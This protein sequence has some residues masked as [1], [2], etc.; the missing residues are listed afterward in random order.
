MIKAIATAL[1]ASVAALGWAA[2]AELGPTAAGSTNTAALTALADAVALW[3]FQ[4]LNDAA[5]ANSV[6]R[7]SGPAKVG[8]RLFGLD[9]ADSGARGGDGAVAELGA[10][11][12]LAGAGADDKLALRGPAMSLYTR[13]RQPGGVWRSCGIVSKYGGHDRLVYN[14]YSHG[15]DLGFELGTDQGLL[16][17]TMPLAELALEKWHDVIIRY[18]GAFL[19]MWVDGI[20]TGDVPAAG[21][22]RQGNKEPLVL[23]GYSMDSNPRGPFGGLLDT[24]AIWRRAL[25]DAEIV[26]LSG[27]E[28]E[29]RKHQQERARQTRAAL[30]AAVAEFRSLIRTRQVA[31][32]ASA[33]RALRAWM[34][35]NDPHYPKYHFTGPESWINDP[36]GPIKYAGRY[37][38]FYQFDPIID[39]KRRGMTWGHAVSTNVVHWEDWP[40]ALWPDTLEDRGGV[41]SGNTF[42]DDN[43]RLCAIYTGNV[44]GH[45]ETYGILARSADEGVTWRKQVVLHN[46][47]RPNPT[48]PVH[49]DDFTWREGG[50]W[51]QLIGGCTGGTNSQGAA[52]LWA[53]RDLEHWRLQKNIAPG[54]RL[55]E[56]WELPYLVPLGRRDVLLV[57]CGNP[58]WVGTYDRSTMTFTPDQP[59]PLQVDTGHYYS[60]NLNL[61]DTAEPSGLRRQLMLGWITG[62]PSPTKTVPYWQG[63]HSIPRVLHFIDNRLWQEPA[64]EIACLRGQTH[65][66]TD[67]T[68]IPNQL[69]NVRGDALDILAEFE[70]GSAKQFGLKL[71]VSADGH[72]F[73]RVFFDAPSRRFGVDGSTPTRNAAEL[74]EVRA[75]GD[76]DS[77]LPPGRPVVM[78]VLMDRS[79]VE[80]FV[81]GMAYTARTFPSPDALGVEVFAEGGAAPI[82]ALE[83]HEMRSIWRD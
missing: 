40:V 32:F 38:L 80:V 47:Q 44:S 67:S 18:D 30:P 53:S 73:T 24:V 11:Y 28:D 78:R 8:L 71:R 42:E 82:K 7:V 48:S 34:V 29:V 76:Q 21:D 74:R 37:H 58:Y 5:G 39:G 27:G 4:D 56:F 49:W 61:T 15:D 79:I 77:L 45:G 25:S 68:S 75:S 69:R 65:R 63:A 59:G 16:R 66:F 83:V 46:R 33:A 26:G 14:L 43:G 81:N 19:Q 9:L 64:P 55:G 54:I 35:A 17:V 52:F 60:F 41:Y 6:L 36:N 13:L 31:P 12:L 62:P 22:L 72:E 3:N 51:R 70:P 2:A 50:E 10:G 20:R 23:G 1:L 57:G